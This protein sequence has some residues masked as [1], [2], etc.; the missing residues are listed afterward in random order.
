MLT[1]FAEYVKQHTVWVQVCVKVD[2]N[3]RCKLQWGICMRETACV[4]SQLM[5]IMSKDFLQDQAAYTTRRE[6]QGNRDDFPKA[7]ARVSPYSPYRLSVAQK[8]RMDIPTA[9]CTL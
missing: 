6:K 7:N 9:L 3:R 4:T 8:S 5:R 1:M 2:G